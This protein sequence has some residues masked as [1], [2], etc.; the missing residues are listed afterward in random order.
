MSIIPY[1]PT[2]KKIA[3]M[4]EIIWRENIA[5]QK[6][7]RKSGPKRRSKYHNCKVNEVPE[8]EEEHYGGR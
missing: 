8:P 5:S 3:E 2:P 1:I 7:P 6:C 4:K